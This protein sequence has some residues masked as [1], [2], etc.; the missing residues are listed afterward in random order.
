MSCQ[1]MSLLDV[2]TPPANPWL[3]R[4]KRTPEQLPDGVTIVRFGSEVDELADDFQA[5]TS[6]S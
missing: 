6:S 4:M 1:P 3:A 5:G 2:L